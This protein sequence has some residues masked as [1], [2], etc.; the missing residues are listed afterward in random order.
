MRATRVGNGRSNGERLRAARLNALLELV[1][2]T[3]LRVSELVSLPASAAERNA[4]ML[5]V[6]GKGGKERLVPLNDAAKTAMTEYRALLGGARSR[7]VTRSRPTSKAKP[8]KPQ[9]GQI[10]MAVPVLRRQRPSHPPAFCA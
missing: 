7:S 3:G 10:E 5:V 8:A 4:R 9:A 1:Y 2:A 6:R